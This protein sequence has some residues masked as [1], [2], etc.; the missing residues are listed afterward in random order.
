MDEFEKRARAL[1]DEANMK[2]MGQFHTSAAF[3]PMRDD[4]I[5][6]SFSRELRYLFYSSIALYA[7]LFILG[8]LARYLV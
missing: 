8:M 5:A 3:S 1:V 4:E 2:W 6:K 7:S